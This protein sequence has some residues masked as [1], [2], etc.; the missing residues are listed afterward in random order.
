MNPPLQWLSFTYDFTIQCFLCW[1]AKDSL[2][3]LGICYQLLPLLPVL[4]R[5]DLHLSL[6]QPCVKTTFSH[7]ARSSP[8][9]ELCYT[10]S[11]WSRERKHLRNILSPL[12]LYVYM[13]RWEQTWV[14]LSTQLSLLQNPQPG[15]LWE[16]SAC[17]T[18]P[19]HLVFLDS[20]LHLSMWSDSPA[21]NHRC[22]TL[23]VDSKIWTRFFKGIPGQTFE[24][25]APTSGPEFQ[26]Y[27]KPGSC[28]H[29]L[30]K[31]LHAPFT[32][33]TTASLRMG[34]DLRFREAQILFAGLV[35][36]KI[37]QGRDGTE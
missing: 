13:A 5:K 25:L 20:V 15:G 29:E 3:S 10:G 24:Y 4:G 23:L 33:S 37:L 17:R 9:L 16:L 8:F 28:F 21:G 18:K 11:S 2:T 12:H 6:P 1:F 7:P 14:T 27:L 35:K 30:S 22:S 36:R 26:K 31:N 19:A 32:R 34:W